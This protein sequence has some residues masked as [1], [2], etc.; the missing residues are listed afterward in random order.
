VEIKGEVANQSAV[1]QFFLEMSD[2]ESLNWMINETGMHWRNSP[3][4][5]DK[6]L[7]LLRKMFRFLAAAAYHWEEVTC[8]EQNKMLLQAIDMI[9][10]SDWDRLAM[11]TLNTF[12]DGLTT[13][14][15]LVK[16]FAHTIE[17]RE[18]RNI[19]KMVNTIWLAVHHDYVPLDRS[20]WLKNIREIAYSML[21]SSEKLGPYLS[22]LHSAAHSDLSKY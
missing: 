15:R 4:E 12:K 13:C 10:G 11:T 7:G 18:G 9:F 6:E 3:G 21:Q 16:P 19:S 5:Y 17:S 1:E 2:K 20:F 22:I 8:R 14:R